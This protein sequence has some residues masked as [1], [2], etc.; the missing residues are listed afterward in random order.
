MR[1]QR[2][3]SLPANKLNK[4]VPPEKRQNASA[5]LVK[6]PKGNKKLG[7]KPLVKH[8]IKPCEN[9]PSE[10]LLKKQPAKRRH[11]NKRHAKMLKDYAT[12]DS[13]RSEKDSCANKLNVSAQSE[14]ELHERNRLKK[15]PIESGLSRKPATAALKRKLR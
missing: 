5:P 1:R 15:R 7:N 11:V 6:E 10:K 14:K 13:D 2:E 9:R 3:S 4:N 8:G 12:S